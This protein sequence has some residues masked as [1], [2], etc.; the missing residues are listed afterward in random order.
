MIGI[1]ESANYLRPFLLLLALLLYIPSQKTHAAEYRILEERMMGVM[2][3]STVLLAAESIAVKLIDSIQIADI[4]GSRLEQFYGF[5]RIIERYR[6]D[7]LPHV[8]L[9]HMMPGKSYAMNS[10]LD[11][12]YWVLFNSNNDDIYYFAG[13]VKDFSRV[14]QNDLNLMPEGQIIPLVEFYL[15][16]LSTV[17]P[18]WVLKTDDTFRQLCDLPRATEYTLRKKSELLNDIEAVGKVVSEPKIERENDSIDVRLYSWR[19]H[20][21]AIQYWHFR[22]SGYSFD[23]IDSSTALL[24]V[25]LHGSFGE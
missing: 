22:I 3:D 6:F 14:I 2:A 8:E 15:N 13:D 23:V 10:P 9:Y 1:F 17:D 19:H 12:F 16:T 4:K 5:P 11:A 25:G 24:H 7:K 20:D 18:Y 21:G